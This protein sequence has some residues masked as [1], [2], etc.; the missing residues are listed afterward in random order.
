MAAGRDERS[1]A[2][3]ATALELQLRVAVCVVMCI[4]KGGTHPALGAEVE[5]GD[6]A[7]VVAASRE[8]A[9]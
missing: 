7:A 5:H 9:V 6:L 8:G 3:E 1:G 2:T 4:M